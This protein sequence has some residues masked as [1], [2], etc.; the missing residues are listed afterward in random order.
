MSEILDLPLL[1]K[2]GYPKSEARKPSMKSDKLGQVFTPNELAS[3]MV[4]DLVIGKDQSNLSLLDPC[5]GPATFLKAIKRNGLGNFL[6]YV[7]LI[8]ID[9]SFID[10]NKNAISSSGVEG[11]FKCQ[12]YLTSNTTQKFD[13]LVMNPPYIRQEWIEN[14]HRIIE[15]FKNE[16]EVIIP[17]TSNLYAFFIVKA[18]FD[19]KIGG[20]FSILIYD[21][22][23]KTKYGKWLKSF[24]EDH[25]DNLN[26]YQVHSQPF[27]GRLID[28]TVISG[29]RK[30]YFLNTLKIQDEENDESLFK[31]LEGFDTIETIFS[32]NRGLRL[33]QTDFFLGNGLDCKNGA[34]P[35]LKKV[36][37][38]KGYYADFQHNESAFLISKKKA[39]S[40]RVTKEINLRLEK[41]KLDPENNK[42]ILAW[43]TERPIDWYLHSEPQY[44]PIVFNYYLRNR[45]F[46]I[47]TNDIA[48]SD[49]FYGLKSKKPGMD[50]AYFCVLNSTAV[51]AEILNHS[52]NQGA[53]LAKIQLFEYRKVKVPNLDSLT[54][55]EVKAFEKIG[56]KMLKLVNRNQLLIDEVDALLFKIFKYK[57]LNPHKIKALYERV[58]SIAKKRISQ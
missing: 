57:E 37:K 2:S 18:I 14:K 51:C 42:S 5:S 49:N 22:W 11:R 56:R 43:Y 32:T 16:Y 9:D 44:S 26:V 45:P 13:L 40:S 52:R 30:K 58:D 20:S 17:G 3:K 55:D 33:K 23:E 6:N 29:R 10:D 21:S 41:A 47:F 46:H 50:L 8:E 53:D 54:K 38:I 34:I 25:T 31:E 28:A 4:N 15:R 36:T 12:D 48:H 24:L 1:N 27:E 7:E 35:F 39:A 19:L